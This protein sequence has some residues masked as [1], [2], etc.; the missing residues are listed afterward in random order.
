MRA[1]T[2]C[3]WTILGSALLAAAAGRH[4]TTAWRATC[5]ALALMASGR[6]T[7][8]GIFLS[9]AA[10]LALL[11]V[12]IFTGSYLSMSAAC[13]RTSCLFRQEKREVILCQQETCHFVSQIL[14]IKSQ[15]EI[16]LF[17]L[18][19]AIYRQHSCGACTAMMVQCA[20]EKRVSG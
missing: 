17:V 16:G 19:A 6:C 13:R 10:G 8:F 14:R 5:T 2:V 20:V 11:L 12:L 18:C 1:G 3:C 9:C 15:Q 4:A 7:P